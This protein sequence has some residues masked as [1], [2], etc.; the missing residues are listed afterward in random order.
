MNGE[1]NP[2][3]SFLIYVSSRS[4]LPKPPW[5]LAMEAHILLLCTTSTIFT[6]SFFLITSLPK[7]YSQEQ[8]GYK[9]CKGLFKCGNLDN[10]YYPFWSDNSNRSSYCGREAFELYCRED[11]SPWIWVGSQNLSVK[12]IDPNPYAYRVRMVRPHL[13][14]HNCSSE[15]TNTSLGENTVG[16]TTQFSHFQYGEHVKRVSVFY[17]CSSSYISSVGVGVRNFTCEDTSRRRVYYVSE[18]EGDVLMQRFP[19]LEKCRYIQVPISESEENGVDAVGGGID[20]LNNYLNQGF[21]VEYII[22]DGNHCS[23]CEA[24]RGVCGSERY[25]ASQFSCYCQDGFHYSDCNDNDSLTHPSTLAVKNKVIAGITVGVVVAALIVCCCKIKYLMR[26]IKIWKT[27]K[28]DQEIEAFVRNHGPVALTRYKFSDVKK[29]TKSFKVKLG[30]GGYG[31]V[32][33]GELLNGSHVAVKIL[34]ASKG[35]GQDFIN[36]V[37]SISRTSHVN[38]V[39]LLGFCLEGQNKAL[40]YEFMPNGSLDRFIDNKVNESTPLSLNLEKLYEIAI[41]IARGLEYLHRGCNTRILHFDIKP[42][43]ILL[44]ENFCPKISDF[45]L[46]KICPRKQS[47]ISISEARGTIGYVA[48]EIWNRNFGGVSHKSDIYSYGMML[49]DIVGERKNMNAEASCTSEKYFPDWIYSKL[50]EGSSLIP[51]GMTSIEEHDIAKRMIVVGLWCIQAFPIHRPTISRVIEMLEGSLDSLEI[52]P[53][54]VMSSP[55]RIE[56]ESSTTTTC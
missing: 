51:N 33:K 4:D 47:I 6:I 26:K 41:G 11:Q 45:G 19:E 56:A 49:L 54:P 14:F 27:T 42:H 20:A 17:D 37:A 29:M 48:P 22:G 43:N 50:E 5:H 52:P 53:K 30:E 9:N 21:D 18:T 28:A 38:V 35:N 31:A 25:R 12:W 46:A 44:D 10:L 23:N 16:V 24:T 40:I 32:Y 55:T 2:F 39:S 36:E 34:T 8:D 15:L 3:P 7:S 1:E 13:A